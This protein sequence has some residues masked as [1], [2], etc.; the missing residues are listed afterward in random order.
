MASR[1]DDGL[2]TVMAV[3]LASGIITVDV[4]FVILGVH[5]AAIGRLE[6]M[7]G[8]EGIRRGECG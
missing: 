1:H 7:C 6:P 3:I 8:Q 5:F 4:A 2:I